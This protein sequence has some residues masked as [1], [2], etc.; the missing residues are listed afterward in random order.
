MVKVQQE[1]ASGSFADQ[2]KPFTAEDIRFTAKGDFLFAIALGIP[3][4]TTRIKSLS[5]DAGSGKITG[6]ELVGSNDKVSWTQKK[7]AFADR[8][9]F[10]ISI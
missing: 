3:G 1:S 8:T 7:D 9:R 5:L 10:K 6:I 2:K 4:K